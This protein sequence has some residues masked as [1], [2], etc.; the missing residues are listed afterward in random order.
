[1]VLKGKVAVVTGAGRGIGRNIA[2]RLAA[3]GC[4][5]VLVSRTESQ[6]AEVAEIIRSNGG[7]AFPVAADIGIVSETR[8]VM[9]LVRSQLGTVHVLINNAAVL[10]ATPFLEVDEDEWDATLAVNLKAPYFLSQQAIQMMSSYREGY[11]I[12]ISSTAALQVPAGLATYGTSKMALAG[13][14]EA[15]YQAGKEHGV[16]V[17]V[18]YPGMTDTKMLR[19]FEPPVDPEKWMMPEDI[20][21]AVVFLLSQSTRVAI[22]EVTAWAAQ[23]DQI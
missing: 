2:E 18:I 5:V 9:D 7:D 13:L 16:K 21:N 3:E 11:I 17:T 12:N 1:M 10:S 22:K 20:S 23:F 14:S 19:D 8:R 4:R 6:I 15:M